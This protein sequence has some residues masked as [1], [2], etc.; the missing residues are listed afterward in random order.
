A[1]RMRGVS[2]SI[3]LPNPNVAQSRTSSSGSVDSSISPSM[4]DEVSC[5]P[6]AT[7]TLHR[8]V[9]SGC[10]FQRRRFDCSRVMKM[11]EGGTH[12]IDDFGVRLS[13]SHLGEQSDR[14][15]GK[16]PLWDTQLTDNVC[17]ETPLLRT[18]AATQRLCLL[19]YFARGAEV[20]R[21][22]GFPRLVLIRFGQSAVD[23]IPRR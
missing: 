8:I 14:L 5:P 7:A 18:R 10:R 15:L 13:S 2:R 23:K 21:D 17:A 3:W 20:Q 11:A 19:E 6:R 1:S 22:D 9:A 4:A 12:G 16:S